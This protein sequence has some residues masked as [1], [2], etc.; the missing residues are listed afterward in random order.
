VSLAT[1]IIEDAATVLGKL[2]EWPQGCGL[3][4]LAAVCDMS[5]ARCERA[6]AYLLGAAKV[7]DTTDDGAI[8][9]WT[10]VAP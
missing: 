7:I 5:D 8:Y 10:L 1:T 4:A 9:R 3:L 6:L 2:Q